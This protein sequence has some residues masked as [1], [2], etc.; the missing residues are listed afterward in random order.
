MKEIFPRYGKV[1]TRTELATNA[2]NCVYTFKDYMIVVFYFNGKCGA[3][4]VSPIEHR[5]IADDECD[6][7]IKAIGGADGWKKMDSNP[8]KKFWLN[9][10]TKAKA[11]KETKLMGQENLIVCGTDYMDWVEARKKS[12]DKSKSDGF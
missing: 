1:E 11:F 6:G 10:G 2:W 8:F 12:E 4:M 9:T 7:L 5:A 3:E